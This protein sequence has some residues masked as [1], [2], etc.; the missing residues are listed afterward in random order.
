MRE[1]E[2]AT[3]GENEAHG[4]SSDRAYA[5]GDSVSYGIGNH[6]NGTVPV[7]ARGGGVLVDDVLGHGADS[8]G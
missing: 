3:E 6:E 1:R 7:S 4:R 8:P 5:E 2:R